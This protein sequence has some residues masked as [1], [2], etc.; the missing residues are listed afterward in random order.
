MNLCDV[1]QEINHVDVREEKVN[2][3]LKVNPTELHQHQN[4]VENH[5]SS[6][7]SYTCIAVRKNKEGHISAFEISLLTELYIY[8]HFSKGIKSPEVLR[9]KYRNYSISRV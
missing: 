7:G 6:Y 9:T 5:P 3:N 2:F 4:T 8:S 1:L